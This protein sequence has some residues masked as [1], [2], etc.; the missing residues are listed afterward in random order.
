MKRLHKF[1]LCALIV[2]LGTSATAVAQRFPFLLIELIEG[3]AYPERFDFGG[4]G[5]SINIRW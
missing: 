4:H 3:F 5:S 2:L 1:A